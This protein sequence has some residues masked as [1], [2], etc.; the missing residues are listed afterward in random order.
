MVASE[1]PISRVYRY[2]FLYIEPI[3]ALVGA[4]YS[5]SQQQIYLD[6]TH[7]KSTPIN[8]IPIS[9][10]I[11]LAQLANL[12]LLFALNEALVLRA[13]TD[14]KVWRAVLLCLLIADIGHLY[15]VNAKGWSIYWNVLAWNA[16]DWGNVGFVYAGAAMRLSFLLEYGVRKTSQQTPRRSTRRKR[17]SGRITWS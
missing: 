2:F 9:T 11:V 15:S 16:I 10:Q 1:P 5:F 7:G 6:L 13:T 17:P 12:Y 8:G 4:Y 14:L 3:S